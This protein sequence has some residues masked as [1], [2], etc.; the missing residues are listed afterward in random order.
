MAPGDI[1]VSLRQVAKDYR[2][3]RPL[4]VERLELRE[5]ETVALLGFDRAAAEVLVDL[6]TAASLPDA[7]DVEIFGRQTR[8]IADPG[9]WLRE[10]DHFGIISERAIL[11]EQLTAEQNLALPHSLELDDL[12][13]G[14][15]ASVKALADEVGV[16]PDELSTPVAA[17]S[18]LT[19]ARIRLGKALA[20]EPRVLLAEHPNA[21]VP[22]GDLPTFAAEFSRI[23]S[24]RHV[25]LLVMTADA[26]FARSVAERVLTLQ[27]ATGALEVSSG[28]RSWFRRS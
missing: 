5:G 21:L 27:P 17:L 26:T 6:I 16:A 8:T 20:L 14:L 7:G 1:V 11:L 13:S 28:W 4:R 15:R 3:L 24:A 18:R 23:V 9:T 12:A 2:G 25:T 22:A 10:L 19:Q